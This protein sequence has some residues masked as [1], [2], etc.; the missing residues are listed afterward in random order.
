MTAV[1]EDALVRLSSKH[2]RLLREQI[3]H[4]PARPGLYA[5]YGHEVWEQLGL[6][7]AP[8]D[9]PLYVGKAEDSLATRDVKTHFG[10]GRTGQS[11]L[12]RSFAALLA[13]ELDLHGMPRNPDNPGH[14]SNYGLSLRDDRRLSDWMK[15]HLRLAI[16]PKPP[17]CDAPLIDI[18][19]YV[20]GRFQPPLNLKDV[21]T[22]W[23]PMIKEARKILADEARV[24][25]R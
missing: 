2:A 21:S 17:N 1:F 15:E 4:V 16:W 7:D 3:P 9:R 14:F 11:T 22:P 13:K 19:Q 18:E 5:I 10:D 23:A 24:W 8:D 12:R 20:L 6:G 25:K